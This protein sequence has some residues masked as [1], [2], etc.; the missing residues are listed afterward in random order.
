MSRFIPRLLSSKIE[1]AHFYFPVIVITGP[2]QSGKTSLCRHLYP[3]YRYTN[4]EDITTRAQALSDPTSFI[5]SLGAH[6]IIDEVQNVPD[7]LSMIQV[8]VDENKDLKFILTGSSNFALMSSL[9]QSLAGRAAVFTL[10]PFSFPELNEEELDIPVE[11]LIF[12]GNYPATVCNNIPPELFFRNY[13]NT[14]VERDLRTHLM[15]KNLVKFD[16]FLRLL[17]SRCGS[18]FNASTLAKEV[19]VSAITIAEWISILETSYIVF[20]VRPYYINASK[21]LTKMPK[22]YFYDTGLACF[23]LGI[24]NESQLNNSTFRGALFENLAMEELAKKRTNAGKDP[25]LY[26]Y[27]ETAGKEIDAVMLAA[28]GL[29]LYEIKSSKTFSQQYVSNMNYLKQ[30]LDNVIESTVIYDGTSQPPLALNIREI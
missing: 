2:R 12:R 7:L 27:R 15:V 20:T 10:L 28:G 13:Y 4:L 25:N 6:V 24:E 18:E 16:T 26:F 11:K 21:S 5:D 19:G 29:M 22:V 3:N 14:Y 9:T 17:A 23:L 1:E 30:K 8:R